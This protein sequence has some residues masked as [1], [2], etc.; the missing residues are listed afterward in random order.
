MV[1]GYERGP[2]VVG[3]TARRGGGE[4]REFPVRSGVSGTDEQ[5]KAR[6]VFRCSI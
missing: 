5:D 3:G 4:S 1:S 2:A 6:L